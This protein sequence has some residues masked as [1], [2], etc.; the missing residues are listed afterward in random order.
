MNLSKLIS[1]LGL[2]FGL[3]LLFAGIT[4]IFIHFKDT[5]FMRFGEADQSLI[6]WYLPFL[7]VGLGSLICGIV[8]GHSSLSSLNIG[9]FNTKK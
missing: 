9:L 2:I 6:F 1:V 3:L 5:F 7:F 8:V 4:F